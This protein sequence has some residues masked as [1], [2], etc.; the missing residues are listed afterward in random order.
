MSHI[1]YD[2][3]VIREDGE[4]Q[5]NY[6]SLNRPLA[7]FIEARI[8]FWMINKPP[9]F[10]IIYEIYHSSLFSY[11]KYAYS[12]A[13]QPGAAF[14]TL[15]FYE[16]DPVFGHILNNKKYLLNGWNDLL[17]RCRCLNRS[18]RNG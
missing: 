11:V 13:Y 17:C 4:I 1:H 7:I 15:E 14:G 5:L 16:N 12:H 6:L 10:S 18:H 9:L 3:I 2:V 8:K